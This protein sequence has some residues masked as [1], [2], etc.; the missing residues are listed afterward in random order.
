M[1]FWRVE[2]EPLLSITKSNQRSTL[3]LELLNFKVDNVLGLGEIVYNFIII[4]AKPSSQISLMSGF[5]RFASLSNLKKKYLKGKFTW[6]LILVSH[7]PIVHKCSR[8]CFIF[9][10]LNTNSVFSEEPYGFFAVFLYRTDV[11][12]HQLREKSYQ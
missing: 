9:M 4:T 8:H 12:I 2:R 1:Y 3:G 11:V 5:M 6:S 10:K 7:M